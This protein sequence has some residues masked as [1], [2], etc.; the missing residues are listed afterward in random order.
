MLKN[1]QETLEISIKEK[2][3]HIAMLNKKREQAQINV[4]NAMNL[5]SK[6][7][8]SLRELKEQLDDWKDQNAKYNNI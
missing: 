4:N 8:T 6:E 5:K 2:Q 1:T 3:S 7:Q